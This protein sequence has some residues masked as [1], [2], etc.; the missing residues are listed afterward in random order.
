MKKLLIV[1][2]ISFFFMSG[3]IVGGMLSHSLAI[4]TDA[5]DK[6]T[7]VVGFLISFLAIYMGSRVSNYHM[8][9]G[10][11]RAEILGALASI[12]LICIIN[13]YLII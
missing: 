13:I 8:S 9:F 4:L 3:E 2:F 12:V 6:L 10:Y 5:A 1:C 11:H 7:D